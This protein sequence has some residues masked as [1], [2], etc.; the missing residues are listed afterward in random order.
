LANHQPLPKFH[1]ILDAAGL[2]NPALFCGMPIYTVAGAPYLT[3]GGAPDYTV[4][5]IAGVFHF[6]WATTFQPRFLGGVNRKASFFGVA[7]DRIGA[8]EIHK[9]IEA[10]K[11]TPSLLEGQ[12]ISSEC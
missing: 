4:A 10:G 2:Y 12:A 1:A 8:G 7:P 6:L 3:V 11:C 9:L 5:G